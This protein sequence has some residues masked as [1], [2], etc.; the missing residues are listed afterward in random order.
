L[1]RLLVVVLALLLIA[2]G[3]GG[4]WWVRQSLPALDGELGVPGLKGPVEV[5]F[6][7]HA[8]P[9]VYA[10]DPADVWFAAGVLHARERLWQMELYRRVRGPAV[11]GARRG[12]PAD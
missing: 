4:W 1:K 5:V 12:H 7:G 10:R 11:R 2:L 3:G 8:V 6:D 9:H